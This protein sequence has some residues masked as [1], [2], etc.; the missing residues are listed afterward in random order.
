M[1]IISPVYPHKL[2]AF[3]CRFS[4]P[5][6]RPSVSATDKVQP[7]HIALGASGYAIF[8][9]RFIFCVATSYSSLSRRMLMELVV[10]FSRNFDRFEGPWR[11]IRSFSR[12][13][14]LR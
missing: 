10:W 14:D 6:V 8:N 12:A 3:L 2:K 13:F 7:D 11:A 9:V 4:P 1:H 5:E